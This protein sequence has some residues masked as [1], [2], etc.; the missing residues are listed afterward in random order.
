MRTLK[1]WKVTEYYKALSGRQYQRIGFQFI[2]HG[3]TNNKLTNEV[4][5]EVTLQLSLF[6]GIRDPNFSPTPPKWIK[7]IFRFL[8]SSLGLSFTTEKVTP[9]F[10]DVLE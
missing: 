7:V 5:H 1:A 8:Y 9:K 2:A 10:K 3:N 4:Q 6:V